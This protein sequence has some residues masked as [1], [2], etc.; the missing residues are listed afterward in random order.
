M[1]V[2]NT[3]TGTHGDSF[4]CSTARDKAPCVSRSNRFRRPPVTDRWTNI[5]LKQRY[6]RCTGQHKL[7]HLQN[8]YSLTGL[9]TNASH[10]SSIKTTV[11]PLASGNTFVIPENNKDHYHI[12]VV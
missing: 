4:F 8:L 1:P 3:L 10:L 5:I 9:Y 7:I 6:Y 12:I 11:V 2:A